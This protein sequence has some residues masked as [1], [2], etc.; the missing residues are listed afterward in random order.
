MTEIRNT[1]QQ[2]RRSKSPAKSPT[3]GR[4]NRA[5]GSPEALQQRLRAQQKAL[6]EATQKLKEQEQELQKLKEQSTNENPSVTSVLP[7]TSPVPPL[8]SVAYTNTTTDSIASPAPTD[9]D[10]IIES[11]QSQVEN[12]KRCK[13]GKHPKTAALNAELLQQIGTVCKEFM[14]RTYKFVEDDDDAYELAED[15]VQYLNLKMTKED[16]VRDYYYECARKIS[17]IRN[18]RMQQA[19]PAAHCKLFC[20]TS[21]FSV[22]SFTY[23]YYIP[24]SYFL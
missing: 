2:K 7:P 18:Y 14:F 17:K 3:M 20:V 10:K 6:L 4:Y 8:A 16:F 21:P 9:K 24:F 15:M 22:L 11:L 5:M 19:G 12:L 23:N 13:T 1:V